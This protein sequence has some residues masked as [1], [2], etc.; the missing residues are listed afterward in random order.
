M[1]NRII[2]VS[3]DAPQSTHWHE[4]WRVHHQC[5]VARLDAYEAAFG[6]MERKYD[7]PEELARLVRRK[8][9]PPTPGAG[10]QP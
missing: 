10:Q 5:A 3:G 4:C 8:T 1:S 2:I 7:G 6:E 9:T